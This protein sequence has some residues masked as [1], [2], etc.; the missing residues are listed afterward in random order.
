M[1]KLVFGL[2]VCSS[3]LTANSN[4]YL[5]AGIKDYTNSKTKKDGTVYTVG[6]MHNYENSTIQ[7][8][9][10]QDSVDRENPVTHR[11]IDTLHVKK[12]N[13][14]YKYNF[15]ELFTLKTS[16]IKILDNLAPTD[17]GKVYGLG[18]IYN[19]NKGFG[20]ALDYYKSDYEQFNVNQYDVSVF[21]GFKIGET[22]LKASVIAKTIKIDGDKYATYSFQDKDYFTTGL[23]LGMNYQGYVAGVGAFFGK[24]I[25]TVMDDGNKVQH[26]AMEQDKTY[27]ASFGKQFKNF[28]I[29]L[30]YSYQNGKELPERQDDVDTKVTSLMLKYK[31]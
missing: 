27:M 30:K 20:V 10:Q 15:N 13:V 18:G 26:H 14:N 5:D 23:K 11:P 9:Y 7:L 19:I 1:K 16:Y 24:R 22:K 2:V 25:F 31:F 4:I 6:T 3:F 21:K 28:D 12:Y 29:M 8:N 17:Q